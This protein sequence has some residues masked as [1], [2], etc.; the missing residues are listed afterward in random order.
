[1][2]REAVVAGRFY[3]DNPASLRRTIRSYLG[4]DEPKLEAAAVVVP[5]AG[6]VY[7]G[8]VAGAVYGTVRM[9]DRF[10]VLGPNH[11]GRG[12]Q[13]SLHPE[14]VWELPFG[15]ATVDAA[16]NQRLLESCPLLHEDRRAH[17]HEHSLEVQIPFLQALCGDV[18]FAA[19]C[20]GTAR[21][22]DLEALGHALAKVVGSTEGRV[23]MI[24]SSDMNH[25]EPAEVGS[26]K[27]RRAISHVL[28]LDPEGL[29]RTVLGEDISMCGFAPTVAV[30][31]ACRD[32]GCSEGRLVRYANSGDVSGDYSSVV[33]YAGIAVLAPPAAV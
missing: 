13:L 26:S 29:Y 15:P 2:K 18:R 20:V 14:G 4:Q 11:T 6:Y 21:R 10:I 32:L 33:G 24:A 16:L 27:D 19:I 1:M 17:Q 28:A 22:A 12:E 31:T 25:F 7:S 9:P 8:A 30:L 3:P 5:H 23:L